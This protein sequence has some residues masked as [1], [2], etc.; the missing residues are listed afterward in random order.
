LKFLRLTNSKIR[1]IVDDEDYERC[2]LFK[3]YLYETQSGC[4]I[5]WTIHPCKTLANFVMKIDGM[6][7]HINRNI[8]DNQKINLRSCTFSQNMVNRRKRQN[9]SSIYRGVY[10][11]IKNKRWIACI[12]Q[13]NRLIHLGCFDLEP[14]AARAYNK[15]A[16]EFFGEF[17][18]LNSI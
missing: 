8:W 2:R 6:L 17:A 15:A 11:H 3:W 5:Q 13:N 1:A 12:R 18:C 16:M 14:Q 10:W 4:G 9:T 7:D